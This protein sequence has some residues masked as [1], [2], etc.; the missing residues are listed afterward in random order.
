MKC[1]R[2][3]DEEWFREQANSSNSHE[4]RPEGRWEGRSNRR[5]ADDRW[6]DGQAVTGLEMG[7]V[8]AADA[9]A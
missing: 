5:T 1:I 8:P 4:K 7:G 2:R 6:P 9:V 3:C